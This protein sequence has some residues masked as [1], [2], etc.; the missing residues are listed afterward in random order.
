MLPAAT[1]DTSTGAISIAPPN[2]QETR[3][4]KH[5]IA[6]KAMQYRQDRRNVLYKCAY[7]VFA[8]KTLRCHFAFRSILNGR[9]R[10]H[11]LLFPASSIFPSFPE[12]VPQLLRRLVKYFGFYRKSECNASRARYCFTISVRPSV[13]LSNAGIV[14]KRMDITSHFLNSRKASF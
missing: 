11:Q 5:S 6:V 12:F 7:T 13:C 4:Q 10:V 1:L 14:S 8:L 2:A 9:S 3:N